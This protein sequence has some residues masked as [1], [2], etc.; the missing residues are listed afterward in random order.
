MA[1]SLHLWRNRVTYGAIVKCNRICQIQKTYIRYNEEVI[2]EKRLTGD[3]WIV[4][5]DILITEKVK[6][7]AVCVHELFLKVLFSPF[8][9]SKRS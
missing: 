5:I 4:N 9:R 8:S 1:Q 3:Q 7:R 6:N 2:H